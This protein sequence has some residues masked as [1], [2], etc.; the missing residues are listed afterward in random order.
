M[1]TIGWANQYPEVL[2]VTSYLRLIETK[3][4][5]V[6]SSWKFLTLEPFVWVF[7]KVEDEVCEITLSI[8]LNSTH[9]K[10][11]NASILK[12][13]NDTYA[14][15]QRSQGLPPH[16]SLRT[17]CR[18]SIKSQE[19]LIVLKDLIF[20]INL[21]QIQSHFHLLSVTTCVWHLSACWQTS[22]LCRC[23]TI[24]FR[25]RKI[26]C[27]KHSSKMFTIWTFYWWL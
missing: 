18:F 9:G 13:E 7:E 3:F 14:I 15:F 10:K 2:P 8:S 27:A 26:R 23:W 5:V 1:N 16:A 11:L 19:I 4:Y 24:N 12:K 20:F 17:S 25:K 21:D 22:S 6:F